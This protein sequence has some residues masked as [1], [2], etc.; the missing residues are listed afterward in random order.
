VKNIETHVGILT[1]IGRLPSSING[2]PRYEL[3]LNNISFRTAVDCNMAYSI[4]NHD[5]K[6]I[7]VEIGEHYG[8]LTL[9]TYKKA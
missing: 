1:I 3:E 5:G 7:S 2:N 6:K 9:N 8:Y 4:P